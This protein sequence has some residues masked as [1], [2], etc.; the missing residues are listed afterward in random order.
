MEFAG[1]QNTVRGSA[2]STYVLRVAIISGIVFL[3]CR[4]TS[5]G[6]YMPAAIAFMSVVVSENKIN[7]YMLPVAV[8]S[9][10]S[11]YLSG[12]SICADAASCIICCIVFMVF[13]RLKFA[14]YQKAV[15]VCLISVICNLIYYAVF[16][17]MYR[18]NIVYM[19]GYIML[20]YALCIVFKTIYDAS[21][22]KKTSEDM[23]YISLTCASALCFAGMPNVIA[24]FTGYYL[25]I[26]YAGYKGGVKTGT[27]SGAVCGIVTVMGATAGLSTAG[28]YMTA[29]IVAGLVKNQNK[30][31]MIMLLPIVIYML[32]AVVQYDFSYAVIY[33]PI[34]AALIFALMPKKFAVYAGRELSILTGKKTEHDTKDPQ[35]IAVMLKERA[36]N[37]R[38]VNIGGQ[39][40]LAYGF[41][42]V[43]EAIEKTAE[44]IM[45]SKSE[46]ASLG[47][48]F[49]YKTGSSVYSASA[50]RCGDSYEIRHLS[51]GRLLIVLSDGMG[52]DKEAADE[53]SMTVSSIASLIEIGFTPQTAIKVLNSIISQKKDRFPTIDLCI[54]EKKGFVRIYKVGAAPTLLKRN[55]KIAA[56]HM[57]ALP[58]GIAAGVNIEY[59]SIR[60]RHGDLIMIM[61]DGITC[62]S[63]NDMDM[64]WLKQ[65]VLNINSGD[66][67]TISDLVISGA[68]QQYGIH[69]KDDMA[70]ISVICEI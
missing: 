26:I 63:R 55:G 20:I 17:L 39:A 54:L 68:V 7:I 56:I 16:N 23:L 46:S 14:F 38:N 32:S 1:T 18:I 52:K 31:L 42:G 64:N 59:S 44:E 25:I 37:F 66:P 10:V 57:S 33:S 34:A 41:Q 48:N 67:R 3:I 49:R 12:G 8:L 9:F 19:A 43:A 30:I 13:P 5:A 47:R 70:V 53:S 61:S 29:G 35:T 24:E 11:V 69:E 6:G 2:K 15:L 22:G 50:G 40:I 58:L 28:L 4:Y 45:Q 27:V 60:L 51:D 62:A 36:E 65:S 21:K